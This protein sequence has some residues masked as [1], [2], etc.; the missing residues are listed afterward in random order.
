[1]RI[2]FQ[3]YDFKVVYKPE[4]ELVVADHLS[5]TYLKEKILGEDGKIEAFVG[6]ILENTN[7]TDE[8]LN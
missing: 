3:T 2:S 6:M 7:F 8:R 5:R 4:K 1:M